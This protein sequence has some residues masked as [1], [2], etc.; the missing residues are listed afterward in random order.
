MSY[1][2]ER[3]VLYENEERKC[4]LLALYNAQFEKDKSIVWEGSIALYQC[5]YILVMIVLW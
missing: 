4:K 3:I 2:Q 1:K 5:P